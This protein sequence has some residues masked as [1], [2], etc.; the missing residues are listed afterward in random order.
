MSFF[1]AGG[2]DTFAG[3]HLLL[4]PGPGVSLPCTIHFSLSMLPFRFLRPA[5]LAL[6]PVAAAAQ[7]PAPPD[8]A[9]TYK[10]ALGLTASPV[11]DGF[12]RN[13]RSLPLGLLYKRQTSPHRAW[14]YGA[15]L[16]Q[17][18]NER[19]APQPKTNNAYATLRYYVEAAV[20]LEVQKPLAKRWVA[21]AGADLGAGYSHYR[22]DQDTERFVTMNGVD[23]VLAEKSRTYDKTK[24]AFLRPLLGIRYNL[25][26]NLY[27]SAETTL[28]ISYSLR[29][30]V[31]NGST[32]RTDTGEEIERGMGSYKE[33][34]MHVNLLPVSRITVHYLFG[35]K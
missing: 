22:Y 8:T 4:L 9:R 11:L 24:Y 29:E 6:L 26:P 18:Y 10:H 12:F 27:A 1:L 23:V 15:V 28:S 7:T 19:Y 17:Q 33:R 35:R 5:L 32:H 34:F 2:G 30:T 21:F 14:R 16:N 25:L 13:N 31:T 3:A 20:G